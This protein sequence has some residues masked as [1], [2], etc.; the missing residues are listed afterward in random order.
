MN[1][2]KSEPESSSPPVGSSRKGAPYRG[3]SRGEG[4]APEADKPV[5]QEAVIKHCPPAR[6]A[7]IGPKGPLGSSRRKLLRKEV[8][9]VDGELLGH[10]LR[11]FAFVPRT[12][13]LMVVMSRTAQAFYKQFDCSEYSELEL[14]KTTVFTITAAMDVPEEEEMCRQHLKSKSLGEAREA[15]ADMMKGDLGSVKNMFGMVR[16]AKLPGKVAG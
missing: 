2:S 15:H 6:G 8:P 12:A 4:T 7:A 3:P 14:Y 5:K 9:G 1:Q 13:E 10:L 16:K 11:K